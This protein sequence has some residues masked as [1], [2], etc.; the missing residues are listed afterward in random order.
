MR[1]G[2]KICNAALDEIEGGTIVLR[3]V[4]SPDSLGHLK[5]DDYQREEQPLTSLKGLIAAFAEGKRIPDIEL[6]MRGERFIERDGC[7]Y[8]QDLVYII[9]GLQ[10]TTAAVHCMTNGSAPSPHLGCTLHFAT[11]KEWERDRFQTLNSQRMKVSPNILLR[12]MRETSQSIEMCYNLCQDSS[13][14]LARR[15]SWGQ[16]MNRGELLTARI[17]LSVI[18]RLHRQFGGAGKV[19]NISEAVLSF[20]KTLKEVGR[21]TVRDNIKTFFELVDS[22]WGIRRVAYRETATYIKGSFLSVLAQMLSD[23]ENFWKEPNDKRLFIPAVHVKKIGQ[24]PINDP[25][26]AG[27]VSG[28]SMGDSNNLLY[29]YLLRHI[30]SGKRTGRLRARSKV[31]MPEDIDDTGEEEMSEAA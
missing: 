21:N 28:G 22:A 2:I 8:L 7:F 10:R 24:F 12:N 30:N 3:G 11:T 16:R 20:D 9:D 14:V 19:G 27:L 18:M 26:V 17:L 6:G 15:V 13:F 5:V 29:Q 1:N 31:G 25:H 23:H 4:I